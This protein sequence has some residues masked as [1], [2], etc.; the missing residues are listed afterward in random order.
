VITRPKGGGYHKKELYIMKNKIKVFVLAV[1]TAI[2]F[3]VVTTGCPSDDKDKGNQTTGNEKGEGTPRL[4]GTITISPDSD[5]LINT[6]LT[7][8]YSGSESVS[9]Q[10]K[11]GETEVGTD[12]N[13]YT[14]SAVGSYTVT[15]S[16]TD[17]E[18]K[19]SASVTVTIWTAVANSQFDNLINGITY[20]GGKF[21]AVGGSI[22]RIAYSSDGIAWTRRS[23]DT[24]FSSSYGTING[25]TFGNDKFVAVGTNGKLAY[26]S[27]VQQTWTAVVGTGFG[28]SGSEININAIAY[29]NGIF[30]IVG[31]ESSISSS[32]D[33]G[34][35]WTSVKM[36]I[37]PPG[38]WTIFG[39][40]EY[41]FAIAYGN[42]KFV[43]GGTNRKMGY[44]SD[45]KWWTAVSTENYANI[46]YN[47]YGITYAYDKFFA[48]GSGGKIAYSSDDGVTWT[49]VADS[50]FGS[51]TIRAIAYGDDKLV[52]VGDNGKRAYSSDGGVTWTD[53]TDSL[54]TREIFGVAY[55]DGKFV[56]G[57]INGI[58]AYWS[59]N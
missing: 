30:V 51:S 12:S 1:I 56:A 2:C 6:E 46:P 40:S 32:S 50:T 16:A 21:V 19:T 14:P 41:I 28:G 20:G 39:T 48:V 22:A 13:S 47:T 42:N 27:D 44:S 59:G 54:F 38:N 36:E 58:M 15:V 18:P 31:N 49:L 26:S 57:A 24:G 35:T 10:W 53:I 23:S 4:S 25:I 8:T 5:V 9:Y 55:G 33:D 45:G 37:Y 34:V 11:N 43:A 3:T 29:G 7:A 17:Y 52:A